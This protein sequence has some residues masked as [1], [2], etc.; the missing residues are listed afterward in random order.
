MINLGQLG[1]WIQKRVPLKVSDSPCPPVFT[2]DWFSESISNHL[3]PILE[4]LKNQSQ[5]RYLEI[6][7]YEGRS[8]LWM[9]ENILTHPTSSAISIDAQY[10][11]FG[12]R[13]RNNIKK[14][15]YPKKKVTLLK[16]YSEVLMRNLPGDYF[17]LIYIDGAHDVRSV[18]SDA[19]N[20]WYV[21]R[22]GGIII[23]DDYKMEKSRFP[24]DLR[25]EIAVNTFLLGY[26]NELELLHKGYQVV[27]KKRSEASIKR[28]HSE[29]H[30]GPYAYEWYGQKLSKIYVEKIFSKNTVYRKFIPIS[31]EEKKVLESLLLL[32]NNG[33]NFLTCPKNFPEMETLEALASR[34]KIP[35]QKL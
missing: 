20:A 27:V 28:S 18:L 21:L 15:N 26:Q 4:P 2:S 1:S 14:R 33:S 31:D 19:V 7:S 30:F 3:G 24:D 35:I 17:D 16:G 29:T 8:L 9:I 22:P 10:E 6:G 12:A 34:L 23:F 11:P 13:L 25:P 32:I 5:L